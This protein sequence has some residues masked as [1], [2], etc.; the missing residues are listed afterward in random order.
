M[1]ILPV[2]TKCRQQPSTKPSSATATDSPEDFIFHLGI[3]ESKALDRSQ[4]VTGPQEHRDP[5][6]APYAFSELGV[7][8]LSSVLNSKQ[9]M[10]MNIPIMRAF[11]MLREM[12]AAHNDISTR[13]E[14]LETNHR[15][16]GTLLPRRGK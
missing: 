9:P 15:G 2:A 3:R 10:Q 6:H 16:I 1:P 8:M 14:K 13:M 4:F 5:R 7:A 12:M 11:V